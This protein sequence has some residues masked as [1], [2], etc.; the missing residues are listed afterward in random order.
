MNVSPSRSIWSSVSVALHQLAEELDEREHELREAALDLL[1]VGVD[2]ARKGV[3]DVL[4]P[5]RDPVQVAGRGEE[6]VDRVLRRAHAVSSP[7]VPKEYGGHGPVQTSVSSGEAG[8][9]R[10]T[11]SRN[12]STSATGTR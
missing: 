2:A 3:L 12:A 10:L 11:A 4:E 9:T 5:A 6:L 8:S 1:G 7:L